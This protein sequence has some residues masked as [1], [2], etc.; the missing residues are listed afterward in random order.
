METL[1]LGELKL[2][3]L[4]G[5]DNHLD[6]GAMFGVVP[7]ALWSKKYEEN[8]K[9]QIPLRTDPILIQKENK[10][11]L[12]DTG[13][14]VAKLTEKQKRNF[15]VTRESNLI[16][17][18][19]ELGM[20]PENI[21]V[22]L[23]THLH[24]DHACGLTSVKEGQ[25]VSTFQNAEI[26][27]TKTEWD[28]MRSPNLRSRNTYWKQNWE[29]ISKQIVPFEESVSVI[30]EIEMIK[31]GGHSGGHAII[32]L[33]SDGHVAYHLGDLLGTHA[34]QNPLWVMAYDDYPVTSVLQKE[35]WL[36]KAVD[37][38]AW[39][40]FYHDYYYRALTWNDKGVIVDS[41][42]IQRD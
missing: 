23:M 15:G 22:V 4:D 11:F 29:A 5:G 19:K 16:P 2:T 1:S 39:L 18:L 7:K 40:T 33:E 9:N 17:A 41:V 36:K 3:W 34:H 21:D 6:G 12:I 32:R 14:G 8:E 13:L 20:S 28:E 27:V 37:E 35:R 24:F 42:K 30:S 26:F 10:N 31:T 25:F 38:K